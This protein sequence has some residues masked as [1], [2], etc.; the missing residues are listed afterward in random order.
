MTQQVYPEA[1]DFFNAVLALMPKHARLS[2]G[3]EVV[4]DFWIAYGGN[5]TLY[6]FIEYV[7]SGGDLPDVEPR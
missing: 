3:D 7:N 5:K 6:E 2:V 4:L 1:S